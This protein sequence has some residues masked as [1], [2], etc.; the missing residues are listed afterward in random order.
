MAADHVTVD[1]LR[2]KAAASIKQHV[3][4]HADVSVSKLPFHVHE[5]FMCFTYYL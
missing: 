4:Q 1:L 2:N 5:L 3:T